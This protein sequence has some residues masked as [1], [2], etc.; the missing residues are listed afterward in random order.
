[1]TLT[2]Q[3]GGSNYSWSDI[4]GKGV[5]VNYQSNNFWDT[6]KAG[7]ALQILGFGD[8]EEVVLP[9]DAEVS[10]TDFSTGIKSTQ[11]FRPTSN[12]YP[13]V[14]SAFQDEA[15]KE[16]LYS[17]SVS[18]KIPFEDL[19][20]FVSSTAPSQVTLTVTYGD[21]LALP[22]RTPY[23]YIR[24]SLAGLVKGTFLGSHLARTGP[25]PLFSTSGVLMTWV[26][27]WIGHV[28][29]DLLP[30]VEVVVQGEWKTTYAWNISAT[31]QVST[32]VYGG[33]L[34][35]GEG[36]EGEKSEASSLLG[37]ECM[38]LGEFEDE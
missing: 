38:N 2:Y 13:G 29:V 6:D 37:F 28:L 14:F 15:T 12:Y 11:D 27:N 17:H 16:I 33:T 22:A 35:L 9:G 32:Q 7:T 1:M 10:V 23:P 26:G 21:N 20:K 30:T 34:S 19:R 31:V 5:T 4:E 18:L 8:R 24:V 36:V 3:G 25:R